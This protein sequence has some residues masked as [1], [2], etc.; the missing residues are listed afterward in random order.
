LRLKEGYELLTGQRGPAAYSLQ[1]GLTQIQR[2]S[3]NTRASILEL[4]ELVVSANTAM[5]QRTTLI[6]AEIAAARAGEATLAARFTEVI[7]TSADET[8]AVALRATNLETT[9]N[10]PL[11][12]VTARLTSTE[13]VSATAAANASTALLRYGI[14]GYINGITGGFV[15]TGLLKNDGSV[16]YNME[17]FSNVIIHGTLMVDETVDT[18]KVT[19]NAISHSGYQVGNT[20]ASVVISV[21]ANANVLL[22][23]TY[24]DAPQYPLVLP[25]PP[26]AGDPGARYLQIWSDSYGVMV[27]QIALGYHKDIFGTNSMNV[28]YSPSTALYVVSG[29]PAGTY[30]FRAHSTLTGSVSILAVELS[31]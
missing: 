3:G 13:S 20:D 17:F 25:S 30:V 11:T 29:Y 27:R 22:I 15:F 5:A 28:A 21:R 6:E 23:A 7:T 12:G 18:P 4:N 2:V 1:E 8:S 31:K 19:P 14:M 10:T 9:I 26:G 24:D 16:S